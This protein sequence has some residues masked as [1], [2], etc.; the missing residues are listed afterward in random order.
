MGVGGRQRRVKETGTHTGW[1]PPAS[2]TRLSRRELALARF[3]H[4]GPRAFPTRRSHPKRAPNTVKI[5]YAVRCAVR[6]VVRYTVRYALRYAV[7]Y[8]VCYAV[9]YA[10]PGLINLGESYLVPRYRQ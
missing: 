3:A 7:R 6:Y 4:F 1:C 10:K 2:P 8:A 5:R 9:R